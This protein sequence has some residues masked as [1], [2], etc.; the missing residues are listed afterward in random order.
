MPTITYRGEQTTEVQGVQ[1]LLSKLVNLHRKDDNDISVSSVS[2]RFTDDGT[3]RVMV[4]L[5][6]TG[7]IE[8]LESLRNDVESE[9]ADL[10]FGSEAGGRLV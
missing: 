5:E 3:L 9:A 10:G 6:A 1:S 7:D 8:N 2:L 4:S